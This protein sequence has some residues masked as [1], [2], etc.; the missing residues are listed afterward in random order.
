MFPGCPET[1]SVL[2]RGGAHQEGGGDALTAPTNNPCMCAVLHSLTVLIRGQ[3]NQEP[4]ETTASPSQ[5]LVSAPLPSPPSTCNNL[6][7][8]NEALIVCIEFSPASRAIGLASLLVNQPQALCVTMGS[9]EGFTSSS[10]QRGDNYP[11]ESITHG[12]CNIQQTMQIWAEF[13]I[14]VDMV[15]NFHRTM[16]GYPHL[17]ILGTPLG[18]IF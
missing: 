18:C 4:V 5:N 12:A 17:Q 9:N 13:Y 8:C 7:H 15:I 2:K 1:P 14:I 11:S 16:T 6:D 3:S 10:V